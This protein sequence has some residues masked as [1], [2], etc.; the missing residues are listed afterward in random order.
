MERESIEYAG[1]T[2]TRYPNHTRKSKR[3]FWQN[4]KGLL[5]RRVWEDHNGHVPHGQV[6]KHKDGNTLNCSID[7]LYLAPKGGHGAHGPRETL[8]YKGHTYGRYP[9]SKKRHLRVYWWS[10]TNCG[11]RLSLHREIY[12]DH[13]GEIPDGMHVHHKDDNPLNNDPTNLELLT[14]SEHSKH[15]MDDPERREFARQ[16][17]LTTVHSAA[18]QWKRDNP[19]RVRE[20]A[21][22]R[23]IN[24]WNTPGA[25][26]RHT[27]QCVVCKQD[28]KTPMGDSF[29]CSPKCRAKYRRD[30]G[31]DDITLDC[32]ICTKPFT[33]N[34]Y[35]KTKTCS[36]SCAKR[37]QDRNKREGLR[38]NG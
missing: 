15:H 8:V 13:Y 23:A 11:P 37:L 4:E 10:G 31:V 12:K 25:R 1:R 35:R 29:M 19:E 27:K 18:A 14:Q 6:V 9:E 32:P 36:R 38:S 28:F 21:S 16:H 7:N 33:S 26:E 3:C 5:H 30:S 22:E 20:L 24:L 34:R 17:M 2:Y